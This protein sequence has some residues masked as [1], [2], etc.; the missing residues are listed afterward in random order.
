[1]FNQPF[2]FRGMPSGHAAVMATLLTILSFRLP[3]SKYAL[4][5]SITFSALYISD[6]FLFYNYGPLAR[7]G[8]PLGHTVA[9]VIVGACIGI[10]V[11][12]THRMLV[13][14]EY[15]DNCEYG[16]RRSAT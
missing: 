8:L 15:D 11:A 3:E 14:R 13:R 1:M 6:I 12:I 7:D 10:A 5:V 9:E 4:G 16:Q 2:N